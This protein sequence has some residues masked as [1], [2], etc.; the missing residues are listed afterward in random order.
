[1]N[2]RELAD[3]LERLH[4]LFPFDDVVS[5]FVDQHAEAILT[6]LRAAPEG[7]RPIAELPDTLPDGERL[8]VWSKDP[9]GWRPWAYPGGGWV[10]T[11]TGWNE[12]NGAITR[13]DLAEDGFTHWCR[14]PYLEPPK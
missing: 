13:F 2:N 8:T 9:K 7:W 3:E 6:A 11:V 14:N 4:S 10:A 5:R 1:V 12:F